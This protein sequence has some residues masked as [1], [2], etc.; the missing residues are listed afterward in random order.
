MPLAIRSAMKGFFKLKNPNNRKMTPG[1]PKISTPLVASP[2]CDDNVIKVI[3]AVVAKIIAA[4]AN[5]IIRPVLTRFEYF[6]SWLS[7]RSSNI[8]DFNSIRALQ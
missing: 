5:T 8:S 7:I 4:V 2:S 3:T 6:F 1:K